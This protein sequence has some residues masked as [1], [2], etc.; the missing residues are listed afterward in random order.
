SRSPGAR[1]VLGVRRLHP[2]PCILHEG[3]MVSAHRQGPRG[4][5][6]S[7]LGPSEAAG[8]LG[9]PPR[10]STRTRARTDARPHRPDPRAGR[11]GSVATT[12]SEPA[13]MTAPD[14]EVFVGIDVAKARLDVAA[15]GAP[16]FAVD[17][18]P[19]GHA[20][21]VARLTPLRPTPV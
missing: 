7:T 2:N 21:L 3:G 17:N 9:S 20:A 12:P 4:G 15:D 13:P 18:T 6:P 10:P 5:R 19:D 16:P 14:P 1:I 11:D 8:E